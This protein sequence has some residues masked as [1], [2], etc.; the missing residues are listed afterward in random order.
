MFEFHSFYIPK[1][2]VGHALVSVRYHMGHRAEEA[3][4]FQTMGFC[5]AVVSEAGAAD[6][7]ADFRER[8][9]AGDDA[10][11]IELEGS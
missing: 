7:T 3:A 9:W 8:A 5:E 2:T 4:C 10:T 6:V 11:I 1:L